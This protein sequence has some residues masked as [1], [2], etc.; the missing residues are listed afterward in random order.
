MPE[1]K[2]VFFGGGTDKG[3]DEN[4]ITKDGVTISGEEIALAGSAFS[5][6]SSYIFYNGANFSTSKSNCE[7]V[8]E[9]PELSIKRESGLL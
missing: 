3:S 7:K 2:A 9:A 6:S 8:N 1:G 5:Y 4:N